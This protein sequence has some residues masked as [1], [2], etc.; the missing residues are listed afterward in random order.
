CANVVTHRGRQLVWRCPTSARR[1][2]A[3]TGR[4]G[5]SMDTEVYTTY[6]ERIPHASRGAM[7]GIGVTGILHYSSQTHRYEGSRL[8]VDSDAFVHAL[9]AWVAEDRDL[10]AKRGIAW[11][12]SVAYQRAWE[13]CSPESAWD[14]TM[15]CVSL[16]ASA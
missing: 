16:L 5:Y 8:A 10:A 9:T 13:A 4:G 7:R 3:D 1:R 15:P 14:E 6:E 11:D 12:E 2:Q